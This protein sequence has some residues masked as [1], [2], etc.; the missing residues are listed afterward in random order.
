MA[1]RQHHL[2]Q[3]RR[4]PRGQQQA[5]VRR[6]ALDARYD[7][8]QLVHALTGVILVH[9]FV[10]SS[11]VSPYEIRTRAPSPLLPDVTRSAAP[12]LVFVFHSTG[13]AC[14]PQPETSRVNL[15]EVGIASHVIAKFNEGDVDCPT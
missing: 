15:G 1:R 7:V 8:R 10:S 2:R 4:V 9:V 13:I 14:G 6:V 5:S 3:V 11:E 12:V